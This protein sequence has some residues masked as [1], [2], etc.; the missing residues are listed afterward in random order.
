[1]RTY[2]PE[3]ES[4]YERVW[5]DKPAEYER[6]V[7]NNR[8]RMQ[9]KKGKRLQR[10]R[11]EK[12][13]RVS[14]TPARRAVPGGPGGESESVNIDAIAI[15]NRQPAGSAGSDVGVVLAIYNPPRVAL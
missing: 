1:M 6:A 5:A 4:K 9:R 7:T 3:P 14:P 8:R 12:V 2:I 11:S 10:E 15:Q 13:E